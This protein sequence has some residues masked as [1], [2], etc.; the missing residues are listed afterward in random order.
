MPS[1][2]KRKKAALKKKKKM[3]LVIDEGVEVPAG[4]SEVF[5][6]AGGLQGKVG[7]L[8]FRGFLFFFFKVSASFGFVGFA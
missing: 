3:Q 1:G 5:D 4:D 2:G 8:G 6:A 7:V